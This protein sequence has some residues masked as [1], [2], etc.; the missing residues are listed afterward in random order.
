MLL[1]V[2]EQTMKNETRRVGPTRYLRRREK[3]VGR[4][5]SS[6]A[7]YGRLGWEHIRYN[8]TTQAI[9]AGHILI[10]EQNLAQLHI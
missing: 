8:T 1:E 10:G 4:T 6:V 5:H 7:I 2:Q 9:G 3:Q